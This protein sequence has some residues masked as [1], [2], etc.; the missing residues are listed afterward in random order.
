M[1]WNLAPDLIT[2]VLGILSIIIITLLPALIELKSPRDSG[3]RMI[4]KE[5]LP[6]L[7]FGNPFE[8]PILDIDSEYPCPELIQELTE[9]LSFLPKL[10]I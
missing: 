6:P 5:E 3:P 9:A 10:E 7:V 1:V 2:A 4:L 8:I